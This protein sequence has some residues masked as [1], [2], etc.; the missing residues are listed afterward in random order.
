MLHLQTLENHTLETIR[1]SFNES[2][3]EYFVPVHFTPEQLAQ[4]KPLTVINVAEG[5]TETLQFM[6]D[7]GLSPLVKQYE[8]V[9]HID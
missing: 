6:Q 5:A 1:H 2:F 9:L 3:R 7:A 4:N 8:M